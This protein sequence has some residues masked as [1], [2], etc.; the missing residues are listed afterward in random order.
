MKNLNKKIGAVALASMV[1]AGGFAASGVQSFA[2]IPKESQ[3]VSENSDE[4]AIIDGEKLHK[5]MRDLGYWHFEVKGSSSNKKD[6]EPDLNDYSKLKYYNP[7][8][9]RV[10]D[11]SLPSFLRHRN[12]AVIVKYNGS[13][14]LLVSVYA[15]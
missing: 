10:S 8:L 6:L 1:L 2:A 7:G 14:H 13:Y 15:D 3:V 5:K 12:D 11:R 4:K 9:I